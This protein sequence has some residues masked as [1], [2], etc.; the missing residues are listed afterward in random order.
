MIDVSPLEPLVN[1]TFLDVSRNKINSF[2]PL[3][4][5]ADLGENDLLLL[6]HNCFAPTG[7]EANSLDTLLA[8]ASVQYEPQTPGDC[9]SPDWISRTP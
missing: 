1:L 5:N 4:G 9:A 2:T 8:R 7:S 6:G 3:V